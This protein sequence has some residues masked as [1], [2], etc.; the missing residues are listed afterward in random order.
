MSGLFYSVY[1][2]KGSSI[3]KHM[4]EFPFFFGLHSIPSLYILDFCLSVNGHLLYLLAI[5]NNATMNMDVQMA[6]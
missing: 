2:L 6:L 5:M 3:F 1:A 4:P